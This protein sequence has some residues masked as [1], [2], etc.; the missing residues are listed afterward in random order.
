MPSSK[1][2]Y[3]FSESEPKKHIYLTT[4]SQDMTIGI[5]GGIGAGKSVVSRVL[6]C[7]GLPVYDCD[8]E[9]KRL[10][11]QD[12]SIKE[13]LKNEFGDSIF[14]EN[15][16]IERKKLAA[17]IFTDSDKRNFVNK[18]VH[19]AVRNDIRRRR[20]DI[21]GYFFIE[22]AIIVTGGIESLCDSIWIVESPVDDRKKRVANRDNMSEKEIELRMQSQDKELQSIS[23]TRNIVILENDDCHPLLAT[24]LKL[25]D[26]YKLQNIYT[27]PC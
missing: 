24:V 12:E 15:G 13:S 14:Q 3:D 4:D 6:R 1:I 23:E 20:E 27:L 17:I 11:V 8:A 19:E 22:T 21:K 9:A 2:E 18:I 25:S 26:K 16:E 10:M 5:T 7:N